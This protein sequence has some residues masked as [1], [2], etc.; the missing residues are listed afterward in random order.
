MTH[1]PLCRKRVLED[2]AP[3]GAVHAAPG[4]DAAAQPAAPAPA[5]APGAPAPTANGAPHGGAAPAAA[6]PAANPELSAAPVR[7][8]ASTDSTR[9][10]GCPPAGRVLRTLASWP[11]SLDTVLGLDK[12]ACTSGACVAHA[13]RQASGSAGHDARHSCCCS[14]KAWWRPKDKPRPPPEVGTVAYLQQ[15]NAGEQGVWAQVA[16]PLHP[17]A[18]SMS[19]ASLSSRA[20]WA[21]GNPDDCTATV[22]QLCSLW[23]DVRP[24]TGSPSVAVADGQHEDLVAQVPGGRRSCTTGC[25]P[26]S[27]VAAGGASAPIIHRGHVMYTTEVAEGRWCR[28]MHDATPW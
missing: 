11:Q 27:C 6:P 24:A 23:H 10:W 13:A 1:C 8:S 21:P 9:R 16:Q 26:D 18:C 3:A 28:T 5:A 2:R 22:V 19:F 17:L 14:R 15:G 7:R 20:G 4:A 12:R 25:R